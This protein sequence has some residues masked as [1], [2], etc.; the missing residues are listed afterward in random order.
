MTAQ[1]RHA[2]RRRA[3]PHQAA[4]HR[5][6]VGRPRAARGARPLDRRG[7]R[8]DAGR[9][10]APPR[11]ACVAHGATACTDL[12]G[13]GLLGHLVEMTRPS[14]VDAETR[15]GRAARAGRRGGNRRRPASSVRCSPPTCG[16]A[17]RCATRSRRF[18]T[19]AIRCCSTRRPPAACSPA[20]RW[21]TAEDCLAALRAAGLSPGGAH[22][23]R[24][25]AR[26][27]RWNRSGWSAVGISHDDSTHASSATTPRPVSAR[28]PSTGGAPPA[29]TRTCGPTWTIRERT[30]RRA[31]PAAR[32]SACWMS[33]AAPA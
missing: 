7:A 20:C 17:A 6:P 5:H 22:R 21:N 1:G 3:D 27:M 30:R 10:T 24:P 14:G 16:C 12:T 13:F 33:P 23:P 28:S 31:R 29:T 19:R 8:V 18:V 25:A 32:G 4:R 15:S 9:R 2:P 26:A 11:P